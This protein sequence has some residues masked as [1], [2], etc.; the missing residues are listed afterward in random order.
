MKTYKDKRNKSGEI[1]LHCK[2]STDGLFCAACVLLLT[3]AHLDSRANSLITQS[4]CNWK[5]IKEDMKN[6]CPL[7]Y[8]KDS[9][10]ILREF[11]KNQKNSDD[12]IDHFVNTKTVE[13]VNKIKNIFLR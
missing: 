9:M 13:T 5:H 12:C 1:K 7:Q 4:Y 3:P 8:H 10:E 11:V 6:H 2:H